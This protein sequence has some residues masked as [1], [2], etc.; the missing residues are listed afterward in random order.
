[1]I[2]D[3]GELQLEDDI[4]QYVEMARDSKL[5]KATLVHDLNA[6]VGSDW[7]EV[8]RDV[9]KEKPEL[10]RAFEDMLKA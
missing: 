1:M 10:L 8:S 7:E 4:I 5:S 3:Q 9:L 2:D 6:I